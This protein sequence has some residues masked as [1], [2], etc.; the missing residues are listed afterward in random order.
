MKKNTYEKQILLSFIGD[1]YCKTAD[2]NQTTR[3]ALQLLNQYNAPVALLSKGGKKMLRDLDVFKD[4]GDRIMVGT[5]LTFLDEK[6]SKA[7]EP[8]A[9]LPEERLF[10]L[11]E[12][13]RAGI[14]TVASFELSIEPS[15]SLKLIE[16]TL[17]DD[18]VD[19]YKIG[20][21]N[22]FGS[23]GN[24]FDWSAYLI[25]VL[26]LLRP[27]KKQVYVKRSLRK[28]APNVELFDDETD[29]ERWVVRANMPLLAE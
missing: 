7:W 17:K 3:E 12:L 1:V 11:N 15:Q 4:F 6:K 18:S 27:A 22:N 10:G 19:H 9:T 29:C 13:H 25:Q 2:G 23:Y 20:K 28:F 16:R 26:K 14:K 24:D 5:T 21:I 8:G